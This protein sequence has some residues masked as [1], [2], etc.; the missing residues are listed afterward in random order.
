[1]PMFAEV[2]PTLCFASIWTATTDGD[3]E[4]AVTRRPPIKLTESD[5]AVRVATDAAAEKS[6]V[7]PAPPHVPPTSS[8]S[9]VIAPD[10]V[11]NSDRAENDVGAGTSRLPDHSP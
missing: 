9:P 7:S 5:T 6:S 4:L 11:V 10:S 8:E 2:A 1:M 3:G